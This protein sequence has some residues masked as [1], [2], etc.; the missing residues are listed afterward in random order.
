MQ[1]TQ[2]QNDQQLIDDD[3]FLDELLN[4]A[5]HQD[6]SLFTLAYDYFL[7]HAAPLEARL[8]D[9][10]NVVRILINLHVD[11]DTLIASLLS[12]HRLYD[13]LPIERIEQ[14]FGT[15]IAQLVKDVRWMNTFKECD[16]EVINPPEQAER[17]RRLLLAVTQD[18][19]SVLIKLAYRLQRLRVLKHDT[20]NTRRCI[21]RETMDIYTPLANRLGISHLKWE[22][23]DLSFRYL[24]PETYKSVA[25]SLEERRTDREEYLQGFVDNLKL[26]LE[27]E[28]IEAE[29][30][31][32][33]KH[34]YSIW[35]KISRKDITVRDLYDLRAVR[36]VVDRVVT[37]YTAL[38]IVHSKWRHLPK[39]FDDY[40]ANPKENGYQSLH[41]AVIGPED[42]V[43]EVQIRTRQMHEF[44]ELGVAAHWRYKEGAHGDDALERAVNSLRHLLDEDDNDESLLE[45]FHSELFPDRV[46]AL[47]PQNNVLDLPKGATPLDFAYHVH[48]EVGHRCRGAKVNGRIVPINSELKNGDQVEILTAKEGKPARDWMNPNSGFLFTR[49]A[50]SKVRHWY[51]QQDHERNL[52]DGKHIYDRELRMLG[53]RDP[54]LDETAMKRLSAQSIEELYIG[55]G[56]GDISRAQLLGALT[57]SRHTD[58]AFDIP[59]ISKKRVNNKDDIQVVGVGNVLT[60]IAQC[61]KPLPGDDIV[62]FITQGKGISIHRQDCSNILAMDEEQRNR[63]L[64]VSWGGHTSARAVDIRVH[65]FDRQGLLRDVTLVLANEKTNVLRA[66]TQTHKEDQSVSMRLTVEV[67]DLAQL[68]ALMD[69]IQ[70]I[71]N[72]FEVERAQE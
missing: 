46:Y 7:Q 69:K 48:T 20:E 32:R 64:E 16:N 43:V 50:R 15:S 27:E 65:A 21:A 51:K 68:S 66:D 6:T 62:G 22:M 29:V 70:S 8:P 4:A 59:R 45:D 26:M 18:V 1:H 41:T 72:V 31:G 71:P 44:A 38:G 23:E 63:L 52:E 14:E 40:I 34:I 3:S 61:C 28:G 25:K 49:S 30:Y 17:L 36:V 56:R 5:H 24:E 55:L 58:E 57:P 13:D 12:D 53:I 42:R 19:R 54:E 67:E 39:E 60:Q 11:D 9:A 33:P 37:C 35:K 10:R 47:T 2:H